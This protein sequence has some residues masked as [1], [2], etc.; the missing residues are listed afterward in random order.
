METHFPWIP[1]NNIQVL[2]IEK[3]AR[4][5]GVPAS[6]IEAEWVDNFSPTFRD[7]WNSGERNIE[8]IEDKLYA[9][10]VQNAYATMVSKLI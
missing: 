3:K 4:E 1:E 10:W 8:E 9:P 7:V 5:L 2:L 6:E